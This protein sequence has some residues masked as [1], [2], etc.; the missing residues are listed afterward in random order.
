MTV[1][2]PRVLLQHVL[3]KVG[4]GETPTRAELEWALKY[5]ET[6]LHGAELALRDAERLVAG[7]GRRERRTPEAA[8]AIGQVA[9]LRS[10]VDSLHGVVGQVRELLTGEV[11]PDA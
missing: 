11:Q 8:K 6:R 7:M 3:E 4:R 9:V 2:N 1:H 5:T 10:A